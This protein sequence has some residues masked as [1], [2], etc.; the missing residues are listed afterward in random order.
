MSRGWWLLGLGAVVA[1]AMV[2]G[3]GSDAG[4]GDG[5]ESPPE[6]LVASAVGDAQVS[7]WGDLPESV[8]ADDLTITELDF[9]ALASSS[10]VEPLAAFELGP[11]GATF[12]EPLLLAV[13]VAGRI[14]GPVWA[15]HVSS[16]G[17]SEAIPL[18]LA[19]YD[20]EADR[21]TYVAEISHFSTLFV[22]SVP[23]ADRLRARLLPELPRE[24]YAVGESF[25]VRIS[26]PRGGRESLDW[27]RRPSIAGD[28]SA[29]HASSIEGADWY[30]QSSWY[31]QGRDLQPQFDLR[32]LPLSMVDPDGPR[33]APPPLDPTDIEGKRVDVDGE[34]SAITLEQT[35]TCREAGPFHISFWSLAYR[36]FRMREIHA[37]G[38]IVDAGERFFG[39]PD[40]LDVSGECVASDGA[41][42]AGS[43]ATPTAVAATE[44]ATA[45][46]RVITGGE[47]VPDIALPAAPLE[48]TPFTPGEILD[49]HI[50][51]YAY[52]GTWYDGS[53]MVVT[54]AHE[55]FCTYEHLHGV[56]TASILPG[57]DGNP[58]FISEMYGEC[59]YGPSSALFWIE[60]PR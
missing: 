5:E 39:R 54:P 20:S 21:S 38:S 53:A 19:R 44:T 50:L 34:Q 9:P 31:V 35:F 1:S 14:P 51:V 15:Q 55:P 42:T 28:A 30:I 22:S 12:D 29:E 4:G 48:P 59:G 7:L 36:P 10:N 8:S 58:I 27:V 46:P 17:A 16:S 24:Q 49:G 60:D 52:E 56:T 25:T 45:T 13:E 23:E 32:L 33:T 43:S 3:C 2:A 26:V 47:G 18:D 11:D 6:A 37:D 41:G 40:S 57:P